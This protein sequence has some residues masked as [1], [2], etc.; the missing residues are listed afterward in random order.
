M[1]HAR[2]SYFAVISQLLIR[3]ETPPNQIGVLRKPQ[4]YSTEVWEPTVR[5]AFKHE[6]SIARLSS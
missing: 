6:S 2:G 4:S 1:G 3:S 5:I